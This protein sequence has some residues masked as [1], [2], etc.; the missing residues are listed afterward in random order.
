MKKTVS[1]FLA[2]TLIMLLFSS[3][4]GPAKIKVNGVK[5]DNEIYT[6]FEDRLD[7]SIS[8][9]EKEESIKKSIA[10]YVAINSEFNN[11]GLS[12][13][14]SEKTALS[15]TVNNLWHYFGTHYDEI[16]VSKQ[17]LFNIETSNA[18]ENA[19]LNFYYSEN[20]VEPISE[21]SIKA[22]FNENYVAVRLVAGYLFNVDENG[23]NVPMTDDQKSKV[24]DSFNS[25]ATMVNGGTSLE[26]AIISLG[27][28]TEIRDSLV[29]S[30]DNSTLPDGFFDA[31]KAIETNKAAAVSLGDYIFLVQRIDVF[32]EEFDYYSTY[33]TDCLK[34]M[35]GEEFSKIVDSWTENYIA[36]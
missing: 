11:R 13:S 19:L 25:V 1:L 3:C 23:A 9:A 35:K 21:D 36:K 6:Y 24:V 8:K 2:V 17:T 5:I 4:N 14:S 10:R 22:Y 30:S 32:N 28:S 26:E 29:N 12:L 18:Y 16:G 7:G 27:E 31:A 34:K 20:G 15:S 33:R